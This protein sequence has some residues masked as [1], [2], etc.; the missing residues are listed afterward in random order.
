MIF[1]FLGLKPTFLIK[2]MKDKVEEDATD[3]LTP[4]ELTKLEEDL[5]AATTTTTTT[6][7]HTTSKLREKMKERMKM[8][9]KMK[10]RVKRAKEK[11]QNMVERFWIIFQANPMFPTLTQEYPEEVKRLWELTDVKKDTLSEK[12]LYPIGKCRMY[13]TRRLLARLDNLENFEW[14]P[15]LVKLPSIYG[16]DLFAN[17][18]SSCCD[19]NSTNDK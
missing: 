19:T 4:E 5:S 16:Q 3:H 15:L 18:P 11:M 9:E 7:M 1:P 10:M 8:A 6:T 14:V 2:G 12:L 13:S 17:P